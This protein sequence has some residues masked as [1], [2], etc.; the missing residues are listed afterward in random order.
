MVRTDLTFL[1]RMRRVAPDSIAEL[2]RKAVQEADPIARQFANAV[3]ADLKAQPWSA[4]EQ[5][6]ADR[7]RSREDRP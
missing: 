5:W 7:Q 2:E 3:L 4:P 6:Q 1:D